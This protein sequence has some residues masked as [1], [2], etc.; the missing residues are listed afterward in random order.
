MK[1]VNIG[2]IGCGKITSC[3][4]VPALLELGKKARISA[5]FD[6]NEKAAKAL[7]EKYSLDCKICSSVEELLETDANGVII[8]TPNHTHCPLTLQ[9]LNAGKNVLVEKPMAVNLK[10]ADKMIALAKKKGLY[11]QVNQSLRFNASYV[12]IKKLIESGTIGKPL[13]IRCLRASA[14]SP[15]KGW[16]P[17]ATWFTQKSA[18]GGIIMDI[19]VH[20]AD[21]MGWYFGKPASICS[22]NRKRIE[23]NNVPD[24]VTALFDFENGAT[25]VLELSWT[26]PSGGGLLEIYGDKGTIRMG[27]AE[28]NAGGIM[29]SLDGGKYKSRKAGKTKNSYSTFIDGIKGKTGVPTPEEIGRHALACCMAIEKSGETGKPVKAN[30]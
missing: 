20:M 16:S 14:S 6:L 5:I 18:G 15:D 8:S 30:V 26:I 1:C 3:A 29:L 13:H 4:H 21:M 9:S 28:A 23:K 7:K 25:G 24:S 17:G 11:L 10:D 19:A 12:K 2:L 27:F 22:V